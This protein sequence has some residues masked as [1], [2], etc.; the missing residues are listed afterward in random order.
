MAYINPMYNL[1]NTL[2]D[3]KEIVIFLGAD[4]STEGAQGEKRFPN[5]DELT[6]NIL[7]D[8]GFDLFDKKNRIENF[9]AVI[10]KWEMEKN[11]SARLGKYLYGE[12]GSAHYYL[13]AL[14]IA[15]FFDSNA[16]LYL[17]TNYDNLMIKAFTD[18]E[19]NS[20]RKFNTNAISLRPRIIGSEFQEISINIGE[21]LKN[22]H[23]VIIKLF[24]DLNSQSPIFKQEDMQFEPEVENKLLEWMKKPMIFI[25][26]SFLDKIIK[27]LLIKAEGT[28]PVF[29]VTPSGKNIPPYINELDRVHHIKK[30]FSG[31]ILD[32]FEILKQKNPLSIEKANKILEFIGSVPEPLPNRNSLIEIIH[33]VTTDDFSKAKSKIKRILILS[34]RLD[35]KIGDIEEGILLP[36]NRDKFDLKCLSALRYK[37]L[38]KT[39]LD[40]RPHIVHFIGHGD[41]D[42]IKI[43]VESGK[44]EH[45]STESLDE[46]FKLCADFVQCVIL[47]SCYTNVQADVIVEHI[48]FVIGI[49]DKIPDA[50]VKAFSIAFYD[51]LLAGL[52]MEKAFQFG[53]VDAKC[54]YPDLPNHFIFLLRKNSGYPCLF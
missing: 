35:E 17:M 20:V 22:G 39:L 50:A 33:P 32:L 12:P 47:S 44:V 42:G 4:S 15:L 30:S 36:R 3:D 18:L 16:L 19:R 6:D 53:L 26:Y 49:R 5:F 37:D 21:H 10:K 29:L 48:D 54:E 41:S 2:L 43:E 13:A 45:V 34:A 11:L 27:K 28:S 40:Y 8:W 31:F 25:G 52:P 9:L 46:L 1:A 51:N 24:G 14:S 23:P 38:R 7:K